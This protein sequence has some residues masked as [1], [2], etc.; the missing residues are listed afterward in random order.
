MPAWT[1]EGIKDTEPSKSV[2]ELTIT[3]VIISPTLG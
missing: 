1:S 3:G 2:L